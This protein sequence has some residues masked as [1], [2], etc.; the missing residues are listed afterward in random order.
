MLVMGDEDETKG[1]KEPPKG[2]LCFYALVVTGALPLAPSA[3]FFFSALA[4]LFFS[5]LAMSSSL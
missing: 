5:F 3:T 1:G 4:A 2:G